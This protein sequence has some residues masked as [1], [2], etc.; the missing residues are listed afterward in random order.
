VSL[1]ALGLRPRS[2]PPAA[3]GGCGEFKIL[4]ALVVFLRGRAV[5]R[6]VRNTEC[7][8]EPL[9]HKN[10]SQVLSVGRGDKSIDPLESGIPATIRKSGVKRERFR[11]QLPR[12]D[13]RFLPE[14]PGLFNRFCRHA[15]RNAKI[16]ALG[17]QPPC[18]A[19]VVHMPLDAVCAINPDGLL[20]AVGKLHP[21]TVS[22][23]PLDRH[24]VAAGKRFKFFL[25]AAAESEHSNENESPAKNH[26]LQSDTGDA[27]G[28][29]GTQK[30][31]V[32]FSLPNGRPR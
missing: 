10:R 18:L 4:E 15:I 21:E 24:E 1:A 12:S 29:R 20:T 5:C 17:P 8:C 22:V 13:G 25:R 23:R 16:S 19:L 6:P 7:A 30:R 28:K 14:S 32:A 26:N 11:E 9:P 31:V 3:G 27:S 2:Q